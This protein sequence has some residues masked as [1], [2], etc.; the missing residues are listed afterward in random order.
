MKIIAQ[1]EKQSISTKTSQSQPNLN[2]FYF[3]MVPDT[4]FVRG[5]GGDTAFTNAEFSFLFL[6]MQVH[7]TF[8]M[9]DKFFTLG[10]DVKNKY[11]KKGEL[12]ANG[13]EALE[14]EM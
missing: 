9:M 8:A 1:E 5:W 12:D 13:W 6:N 3:Q 10:K 14:R 7:E 2:P 4:S 11:A